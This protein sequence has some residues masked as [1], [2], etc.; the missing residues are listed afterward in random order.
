MEQRG[1]EDCEDV[2]RLMARAAAI[3]HIAP[4]LPLAARPAG[5]LQSCLV[6]A[7]ALDIDFALQIE[8]A[9]AVKLD[10]IAGDSTTDLAAA[11]RRLERAHRR[12]V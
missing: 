7:P 6:A 9:A 2:H 8:D 3:L 11:A 12:L 4:A 1:R 5:P 10:A